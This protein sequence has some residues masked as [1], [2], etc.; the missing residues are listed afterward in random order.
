MVE[1]AQHAAP[2]HLHPLH[3][4]ERPDVSA[5]ILRS[6]RLQAGVS[7]DHG[8]HHNRAIPDR[9]LSAEG[10]QDLDAHVGQANHRPRLAVQPADGHVPA[11]DRRRAAVRPIPVLGVP[12]LQRAPIQHLQLDF[13]PGRL[14]AAARIP[15]ARLHHP[16]RILPRPGEGHP[17]AQAQL[18]RRGWRHRLERDGQAPKSVPPRAPVDHHA[19]GGGRLVHHLPAAVYR[20]LLHEPLQDG[21]LPGNRHLG[22]LSGLLRLQDDRHL[23]LAELRVELLPL[24][25]VRQHVPEATEDDLRL[26]ARAATR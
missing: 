19:A 2:G 18:G 10:G 8:G 6:V 5:D 15:H 21:D 12:H 25:L 1:H 9:R 3:G 11:V 22:P 17:P 4:H 16:H 20:R 24:L 14:A 23:R 7:L 26:A 13:A